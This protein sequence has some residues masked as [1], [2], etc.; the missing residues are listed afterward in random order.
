MEQTEYEEADELL[1]LTNDEIDTLKF[2]LEVG[3]LRARSEEDS[4][5]VYR[6]HRLYRRI[7]EEDFVEEE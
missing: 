3:Q 2:A 6:F 1:A 5:S 7:V 4:D